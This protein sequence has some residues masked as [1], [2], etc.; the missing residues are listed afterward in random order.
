MD[1]EEIQK[2]KEEEEK[3]EREEDEEIEGI[4]QNATLWSKLSEMA[5][6]NEYEVTLESQDMHQD[7]SAVGVKSF[8]SGLNLSD[9]PV[10]PSEDRFASVM[11]PNNSTTDVDFKYVHPNFQN[12]RNATFFSY[13]S[14]QLVD[15]DNEW[16]IQST[17]GKQVPLHTKSDIHSSHGII[18]E[19]PSDKKVKELNSTDATLDCHA[20]NLAEVVCHSSSDGESLCDEVSA[21]LLTRDEL[22]TL[23]K[24]L[25]MKKGQT[26]AGGSQKVL[27]TVGLV[28]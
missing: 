1:V 22:L 19:L 7:S 28:S 12:K 6:K 5:V 21:N 18:D 9:L 8:K 15:A 2:E 24:V 3:I 17:E 13:Q 27:T 23:F 26:I 10:K 16:N 14:E 20:E 11:S 4:V 25:H